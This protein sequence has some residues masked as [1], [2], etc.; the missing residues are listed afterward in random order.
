MM[1][2]LSG[3]DPQTS[4]SD[5]LNN[6][7]A[8][9]ERTVLLR[10]MTADSKTKELFKSCRRTDDETHCRG[11]YF[12]ANKLVRQCMRDKGYSFI[13]MD[14]Y[15]SRHENPYSRGDEEHGGDLKERMCSWEDYANPKCYQST[16]LFKLEH[17][18]A[19]RNGTG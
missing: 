4:T 12:D 16:L 8:S 15:R 10:Q 13:D 14:F 7:F 5:T 18:W 6:C 11:L 1:V 2:A 19:F 3:C 9:S 17:W